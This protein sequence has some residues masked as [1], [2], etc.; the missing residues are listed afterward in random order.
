M[1]ITLKT[2]LPLVVAALVVLLD[3]A[4]PIKEFFPDSYFPQDHVYQNRSLRFSLTFRENWNI[5]TDPNQM[6]GATKQLARDLQ[7]RSAELLFIG[8]TAEAT[9]GVRGIAVNLNVPPRQYAESIRKVNAADVQRDL[10]ITDLN[11]DG[12]SMSRWDYFIR[13]FRFVEFFFTLDTY[14]IRIAFWAKPDVFERFEPVYV[15]IMS[16]LSFED[17]F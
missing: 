2:H 3:C 12:M 14:D 6:A 7:R 8:S 17:P 9:Q 10:G 15:D 4:G 1:K 5:T 16:S 11:I 13:D